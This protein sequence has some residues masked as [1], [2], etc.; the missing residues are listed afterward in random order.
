MVPRPNRRVNSAAILLRRSRKTSPAAPDDP[1]QA[2]A[3]GFAIDSAARPSISSAVR[4]R[5][6]AGPGRN[7]N[8]KACTEGLV[9]LT[10]GGILSERR[11][12]GLADAIA[13]RPQDAVALLRYWQQTLT[14]IDQDYTF[15]DLVSLLRSVDDIEHL[16]PILECDV[17]AFLADADH[18]GNVGDEQPMQYLQVHNVAE[19]TT[20][21]E[22]PSQPDEPLDWMDDEEAAERDRL[23]SGVATLTGGR[24]PLKLVDATGDD[25]IT[26]E[27]TLR[28]LRSPRLHGRWKP[29]YDLMREFAGWGRWREP[30]EGYF[31]Q[32]PDIDPERY[33]GPFALDLT[34]LSTLLHLPL[35]Y[36]PNVRFWSGPGTGAGDLLFE[37]QLTITFGE[38]LRAIFW[39]LGFHGS[40]SDRDEARE[41]LRERVEAVD[42]HRHECD[43]D[44]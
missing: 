10:R 19:L 21:E 9:R 15:G 42:R 23:D 36:N 8:V 5:P 11:A 20:Y 41:S 16:S 40:P 25:P 13:D 31:I 6:K 34:P 33:E 29:P 38:F 44:S 43:D 26:G 28:R 22:D 3:R 4:E 32:H 18:P 12:A 1:V 7:W 27:P 39:E 14:V 37:T 2:G 24:K 35:R 17:A 30:Y